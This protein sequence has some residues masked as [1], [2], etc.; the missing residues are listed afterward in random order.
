MPHYQDGVGDRETFYCGG[1]ERREAISRLLRSA[2][3]MGLVPATSPC[4]K[5]QGL[6]A[7]CELATSPATSRRDQSHRVCRSL[8]DKLEWFYF[9]VFGLNRLNICLDPCFFHFSQLFS[10]PKTGD[11]IVILWSLRIS[12]EFPQFRGLGTGGFPPFRRFTIPSVKIWGF[13]SPFHRSFTPPFRVAQSHLIYLKITEVVSVLPKAA[14][15]LLCDVALTPPPP[16][17]L[18]T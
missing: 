7:S 12:G 11:F 5:S 9:E 1:G 17:C 4:N 16:P 15:C 13:F 3:T 6:V 18:A 10:S 2:H 8:A 14:F